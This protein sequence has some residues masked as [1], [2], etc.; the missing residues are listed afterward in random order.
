[1]LKEF[2]MKRFDYLIPKTMDELF[3]L[4]NQYGKKSTIIA[5]GT[6]VMVM[7]KK[8]EIS[9]DVLISLTAIKGLDEI[10]FDGDLRIG[11]MVT[12][13]MI[14]KSNL[15]R[16]QFSCLSDAV[17]VLGSTQIRNVATIGGNICNA[18]PSCDTGP[19]LL[20]LDARLKLKS[21]KSERIIPIDQFFKGPGE[22]ILEPEEI[23]TEILIPKPLPNTGS[24]YWKHQRRQALDLPIVGI[25]VLISL[26]KSTVSNP[27]IFFPGNNISKILD[28]L[29]K[30]D[31][32][33][34]EIRI[35]LGVSAPTPIRVYKAEEL[36]RGKKLSKELFEEVAEISAKEAKPRDTIRGEAWYR[37]EIINVYVRRMAMRCIE[38]ILRPEET[39]PIRKW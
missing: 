30:E 1:M 36:L 21:S 8:N 5:G 27:D 37:R 39:I 23:L 29:E 28:Q 3:S 15:I 2:E 13:R 20:V 11:S 4:L 32:I 17:D 24:S 34:N 38:R 10:R 16:E 14:E 26:N 35:A 18:A 25:A 6:D 12:H 19:P 9:P 7:I 22:T 31:L 33:C